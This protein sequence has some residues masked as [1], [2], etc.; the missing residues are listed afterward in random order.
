MKKLVFVVIMLS[1]ISCKKDNSGLLNPD[2]MISIW[3]A[4]HVG[5][6][7]KS[8]AHLSNYEIVRQAESLSFINDLTGGW[9]RG[10]AK[11][12]RDTVNVRLLMYGTD[13]IDQDGNYTGEFIESKDFVL[14]RN[15]APLN[16]T[17]VR[18]TIAYIPNSIIT[19][20]R[21]QIQ[22]AYATGDYETVYSIFDKAFTFIPI[23]GA[24]WRTLKASGQN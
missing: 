9:L 23:T 13:I 7:T 6:V 19:T 21:Q 14:R 17:P 12:Q 22:A 1:F 16:A 20:A 3:P 11:H 8:D 18:D 15:L 10:F 5:A 24:E 2:A 4:G